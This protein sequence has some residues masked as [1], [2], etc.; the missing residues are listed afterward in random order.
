[1]TVTVTADA[2]GGHFASSNIDV[3][4]LRPSEIILDREKLEAAWNR[5]F[6]SNVQVGNAPNGG[7]YKAFCTASAAPSG[8]SKE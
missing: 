2:N 6:A 1:M 5:A 4:E 8:K 7:F 3:V